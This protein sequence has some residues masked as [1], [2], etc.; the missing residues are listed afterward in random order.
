MDTKMKSFQPQHKEKVAS[1]AAL[2]DALRPFPFTLIVISH[3]FLCA[4]PLSSTDSS[5]R[6]TKTT[7]DKK[8]KSPILKNWH[9]RLS[10]GSVCIFGASENE[11]TPTKTGIGFHQWISPVN[12]THKQIANPNFEFPLW[13]CHSRG[14]R[15]NC[16]L[17]AQTGRTG[18]IA[19]HWSI[20]FFGQ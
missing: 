18:Q 17:N 1:R 5:G 3:S 7:N 15:T 20:G 16:V 9:H 12:V 8:R 19:V 11:T 14:E 6:C 10:A 2:L 13:A 4:W